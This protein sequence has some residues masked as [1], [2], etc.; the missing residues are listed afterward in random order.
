MTKYLTVTPENKRMDIYFE[1]AADYLLE[2]SPEDAAVTMT[3]G[4]KIFRVEITDDGE[5]DMDN[6][7]EMALTDKGWMACSPVSQS[8]LC[9]RMIE[10]W[11]L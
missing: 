3:D 1:S 10:W 6:I 2:D 9:R 4:D 11:N 8:G 7:C 5:V